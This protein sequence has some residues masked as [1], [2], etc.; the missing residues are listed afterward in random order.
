VDG[1]DSH[2]NARMCSRSNRLRRL[3]E[4]TGD[5]NQRLGVDLANPSNE[6]GI[7]G[8]TCENTLNGVCLV[9]EEEEVE[10]L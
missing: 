7:I 8:I 4:C 5:L 3:L 9:S 1:V 2:L 6:V 10:H